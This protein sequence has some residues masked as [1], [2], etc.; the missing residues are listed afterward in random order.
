MSEEVITSLETGVFHIAI[1]RPER[2]NALNAA[3]FQGL[4][5]ALCTAAADPAIRVVTLTGAGNQVFCAGVDLKSA[6]GT[7]ESGNAFQPADYRNLLQDILDCPIP[8]VALARGHVIAGGMG[9]LLACDLALACDDVHFSTPEI[10]V[11]MYPMMVL[12]LLYRHVGRKRAAEVLLLGER[13]SASN[14]LDFGIINRAFPRERFEPEAIKIVRNLAEKSSAIL[15]LG[16][17]AAAQVAGRGLHEDLE[18][19]ESA[20]S[21]VMACADSKEGLRAFLEKRKP[22]WG[23]E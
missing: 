5:G 10:H 14:A 16:K 1:H 23:H 13:F 21:R 15:R 6:L 19:L 22:E 3:V 18:Y 2:R 11:G 9:I 4:R 12:S 17:E 20:L 7:P 8:T